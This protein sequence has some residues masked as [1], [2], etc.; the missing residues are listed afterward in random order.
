M[1][2]RVGLARVALRVWGLAIVS[3]CLF[4]VLRG[5][6]RSDGTVARGWIG[7][8]GPCAAGHQPRALPHRRGELAP[9]HRE[10]HRHRRL[11]RRRSPRR[12]LALRPPPPHPRS[13][14]PRPN[15]SPHNRDRR[16]SAL[17]AFYNYAVNAGHIDTVP[18]NLA[19]LRTTE[20]PRTTPLTP[21]E[22][23]YVW[24]AADDLLPGEQHHGAMGATPHRDRLMAYLML[25]GLRPRQITALDL[26]DLNPTTHTAKIL[27]AKGDGTRQRTLSLEVW[28]ALDG[29][30]P[31]RKPGRDNGHEPLLTSRAGK[32]LD[33]NQTP[34][35]V[36]KRVLGHV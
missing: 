23:L 11:Q 32:R 24:I 13:K 19:M 30:L 18:L 26:E 6:V 36:L 27:V 3:S 1:R 20:L 10:R 29:Y 2:V 35:T 31:H 22:A 12:N 9:L 17:S 21:R 8:A 28:G 16:L 25:D 15:R 4:E 7:K 33:S 14:H 34:T 5:P